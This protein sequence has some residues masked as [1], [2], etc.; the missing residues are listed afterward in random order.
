MSLIISKLPIQFY[1]IRAS[2]AFIIVITIRFAYR[3]G[4]RNILYHCFRFIYSNVPIPFK[5]N[6]ATGMNIMSKGHLK[7]GKIGFLKI[8]FCN[9][10]NCLLHFSE[11]RR[12]H[13]LLCFILAIFLNTAEIGNEFT[14]LHQLKVSHLLFV[15]KRK[16][17]R[18]HIW[19]HALCC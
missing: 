3:I 19:H 18:L 6:V 1:R 4:N 10:N 9:T 2:Y 11:W 5:F 7:K 13:W 15:L 12:L 8:P 16:H 17:Q 14:T